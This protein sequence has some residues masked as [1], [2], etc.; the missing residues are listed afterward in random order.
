M[1]EAKN[2]TLSFSFYPDP[3]HHPD[4][5]LTFHCSEDLSFQELLDFFKRFAMAMSF[6]PETIE[7]YLEDE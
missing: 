5:D 4:I 7:K 1:E 3:E 6:S 2:A